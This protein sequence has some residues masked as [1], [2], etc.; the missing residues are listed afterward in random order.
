VQVDRREVEIRVSSYAPPGHGKADAASRTGRALAAQLWT[1]LIHHD[2]KL[3]TL[4][5]EARSL[6]LE[7]LRGDAQQRATRAASDQIAIP[8]DGESTAFS[9]ARDESGR[10]CASGTINAVAITVTSEEFEPT[11]VRLLAI[12]DPDGYFPASTKRRLRR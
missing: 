4:S 5:R 2:E 1:D 12:T 7:Q 6:R 3:F 8:V 10:W 11:G 9:L